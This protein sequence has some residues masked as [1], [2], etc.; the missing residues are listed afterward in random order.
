VDEDAL[1]EA[2]EAGAIGGAALNVFKQEPL[3]KGNKLYKA[4]NLVLPPRAAGGRLQGAE[5]LIVDNLRRFVAGQ[6]LRNVIQVA[7]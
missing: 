5:E 3:P 1:F 7:F 2:L 6:D 4:K